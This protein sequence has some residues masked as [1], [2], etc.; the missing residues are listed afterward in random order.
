MAYSLH[1]KYG[2]FNPKIMK[3]N[4]LNLEELHQ[5]KRYISGVQVYLNHNYLSIISQGDVAGFQ[6]DVSGDVIFEN[7]LD[8][9][10]IVSNQGNRIIVYNMNGKILPTIVFFYQGKFEMQN[11]I[12]TDWFGNTEQPYLVREKPGTDQVDKKNL[13]MFRETA[14]NLEDSTEMGDEPVKVSSGIKIVG[15]ESLNQYKAKKLDE[16]EDLFKYVNGGA[17]SVN[18]PQRVIPLDKKKLT[19]ISKKGGGY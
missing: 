6:M 17:Q 3:N 4:N 13:P 11:C 14:K 16:M 15:K 1:S 19:T 18:I 2:R 8:N 5:G 7:Q 12:V 10:W 9:D